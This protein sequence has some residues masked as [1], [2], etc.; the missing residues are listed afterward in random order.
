MVY[1]KWLEKDKGGHHF[2]GT[3]RSLE[4]VMQKLFSSL[5]TFVLSGD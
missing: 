2:G 5:A 4:T 3:D 1:I